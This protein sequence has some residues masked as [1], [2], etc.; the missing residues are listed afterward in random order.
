M[1]TQGTILS[2]RV[3]N[4]EPTADPIDCHFS[5]TDDK[6][7]MECLLAHLP[8]EECHLNLPP[9]SAIDNSLDM[10]TIKEQQDADN[11]LQRQATK[12]ANRYVH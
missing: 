8:D 5:V 2:I 3:R 10:E 9:D 7:M 1:P 12:Y 4:E 6:E 11:N